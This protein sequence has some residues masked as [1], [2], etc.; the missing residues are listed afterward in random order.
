MSE[1]WVEEGTLVAAGKTLEY[2][3]FGAP[4]SD[5]PTVVLL[6]EGLGCVQLWRDFPNKIVEATGFGVFAYSRAGYGQSDPTQLPRPLN[7]MTIEATDVL[8]KVLDTIAATSV[9]LLGH[10]DGATIAAIHAGQ[11]T[12]TRIKGIVLLAPHFFTEAKGLAS[13]ALASDAYNTADLRDRLSKYHNNPDNAF[14][15][16]ND[17]WLHPNFKTWNV[18]DV[19]DSVCVPVL[20]VQGEDDPYGTLKQI[21]IVKQRVKLAIVTTLI[22]ADCRHTPH[23]EHSKDVISAVATFCANLPADTSSGN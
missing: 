5:A 6:H 21:D 10:S 18:V 1:P 20:A 11:V 15:G 23:L 3:C 19:L 16:W 8:P 7:Y 12:D 9:V 13:I 4:P 17:A 2:R 22:L 14:R